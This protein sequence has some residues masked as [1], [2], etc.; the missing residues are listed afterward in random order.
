[1]PAGD[2]TVVDVAVVERGVCTFT[3]K[4]ASV[5]AAGGYDAV[6][7]FN[8]TGTGHLISVS[9]LHVTVFA[10]LAGGASARADVEPA[11]CAS[12][13]LVFAS[14]RDGSGAVWSAPV[15]GGVG[16]PLVALEHAVGQPACLDDGHLLFVEHHASGT[17]LTWLDRARPAQLHRIPLPGS[18]AN[19]EVLR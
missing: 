8:R 17:A 14:D 9:G 18:V 12:G 10:L 19:P 5:I 15:S 6:L 1:M 3:E 7:V 13:T 2:P 4:V 11:W 16:T